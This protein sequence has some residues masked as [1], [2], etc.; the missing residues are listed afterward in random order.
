MLCWYS[1]VLPVCA[2]IAVVGVVS[3][4]APSRTTSKPLGSVASGPA[5]AGG[6]T[7]MSG[8]PAEGSGELATAPSAVSAPAVSAAPATTSP[9]PSHGTAVPPPSSQSASS[10]S[11]P[12]AGSVV[13][14][15][16]EADGRVITLQ[17]GQRLTVTLAIN[18]TAPR[19]LAGP[20]V[21][22]PLQPL[23]QDAATGFP[24]LVPASATFTAVRT[25]S[26]AVTAHTDYACLHTKPACLP[27]QRAFSMT[28]QVLPAPGGRAGPQP[29]PGSY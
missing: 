28:V 17:V 20:S 12:P 29:V 18:W 6:V 19:A 3:A 5:M 16:L 2:A 14:V 22:A 13:A 8:G 11:A 4:C 9:S 27:A 21:T 23:R 26:A 1:R 25:G 7:A 10:P 15:G 24:A